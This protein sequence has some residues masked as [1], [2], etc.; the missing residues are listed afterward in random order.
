MKDHINMPL[1][2]EE[3]KELLKETKETMATGIVKNNA[4]GSTFT[5]IDLW[6]VQKKH[7]TLGSSTRW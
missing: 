6:R 2:S 4:S 7:K 3:M 1:G 5:L